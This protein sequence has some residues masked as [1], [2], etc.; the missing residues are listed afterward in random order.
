MLIRNSIYSYDIFDLPKFH[1]TYSICSTW[2]LHLEPITENIL[3]IAVIVR[4]MMETKLLAV[5]RLS[6]GG[7]SVGMTL[8]KEIM[9]MLE[10]QE[11]DHMG[12]YEY[13]G[14]IVMKKVE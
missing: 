13:E 11:G 6:T 9:Q 10:V 2:Y 7:S 4:H 14:K 3:L 5:T 8:P 1:L 12:F